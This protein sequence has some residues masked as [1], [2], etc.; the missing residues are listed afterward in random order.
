MLPVLAALAPAV[1][2]ALGGYFNSR[3]SEENAERNIAM[4]R[5]FAQ[6]GIRWKVADA[7]AAGIHP[8]AALGAQTHSFAPVSVG[9]SSMGN[10]LASMG[11]GVG[12]AIS[13][14]QTQ[15]ERTATTNT[16]AQQLQLDNM[17]LQ[18][19]ILASKLRLMN[20]PSSV[21]PPL[22]GGYPAT[23]TPI[24]P[25]ID[26]QNRVILNNTEIRGNPGWSPASTIQDQ[27]G[28]WGENVYSIP[29]SIVDAWHHF[30]TTSPEAAANWAVQER[31]RRAR[32]EG[33]PIGGR[34]WRE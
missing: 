14:T 4:Q 18:N 19:Q 34:H 8:L 15:D 21:N 13:A 23:E 27:Y 33:Y 30:V 6:Q 28:E 2:S 32:R 26:P 20:Q 12:R 17:S 11:Q 7:K 25:K 5:E 9:G 16:M 29:K 3:A 31:Y 22:P 24:D 1:G 10:A